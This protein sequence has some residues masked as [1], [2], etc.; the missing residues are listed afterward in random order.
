MNIHNK[1]VL[2]LIEAN[3]FESVTLTRE[4]MY[5]DIEHIEVMATVDDVAQTMTFS[6]KKIDTEV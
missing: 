2:K 4:E 5:K 1:M 6:F 3:N